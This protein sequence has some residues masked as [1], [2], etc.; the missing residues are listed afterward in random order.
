MLNWSA[1]DCVQYELP[2]QSEQLPRSPWGG[3]GPALPEPPPP[4]PESEESPP[5][6]SPQPRKKAINKNAATLTLNLL[7]VELL[8]WLKLKTPLDARPPVWFHK[9][10]DQDQNGLRLDKTNP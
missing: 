5:P 3:V 10:S 7:I 9:K 1:E 6:V 4:P 8:S 2:W